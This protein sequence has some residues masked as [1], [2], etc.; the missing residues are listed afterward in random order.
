MPEKLTNEIIIGS[1]AIIAN[2]LKTLE[3]LQ[4]RK[5]FKTAFRKFT[6]TSC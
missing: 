2:V 1:G 6:F 5:I 3:V 4:C